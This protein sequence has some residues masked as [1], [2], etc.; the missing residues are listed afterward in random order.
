[1][2]PAVFSAIKQADNT[3][4]EQLLHMKPLFLEK[5]WENAL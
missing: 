4:Q 5:M 2:V 1:M 3:K